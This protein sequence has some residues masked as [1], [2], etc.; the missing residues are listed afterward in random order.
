MMRNNQNNKMDR[1]VKESIIRGHNNL[2]LQEIFIKIK[3]GDN[4]R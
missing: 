3:D 4:V 2:M 1:T